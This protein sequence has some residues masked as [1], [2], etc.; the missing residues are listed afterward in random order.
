MLP[1]E[2]T[3]L[4]SDIAL[5][6]CETN[7]VELKKALNGTPHRLYDT[8]SSFAN[9]SGGGIIIFGI[10]EKD[11][12]AAC[13]VY[14]PQD[15]QI[16]VM[17]QANQMS[18]VLRPLFTVASINHKIIVSAEI[19]ECDVSEKPCYYKGTGKMR[20]SFI[21]VGDA[22]MPMTEYEI[23]SFEAFK[24]K[25]HDELRPIPAGIGGV[26]NKT[27]LGLYF[28]KIRSEKP[29]LAALT[30]SQ[31]MQLGGFEVDGNPTIASLLLFGMYPQGNFPQL[32]TTAVVVPGYEM[33]DI[34]EEDARFLDNR[35]IEGT[36][37]QMLDGSMS[38][39]L[40][41]MHVR[42]II[43]ESGKREDKAEY[44]IKAVREII[45]NALTHRDY[46]IHTENSP[47]RI[48][49]FSDR[50]EVENPG[51]L[52]G[53][54]TIDNLGKVGADTRNPYIASALEIMLDTENRFSGIPTIRYETKR[55]NLPDPV[56]ISSRGIFKVILYNG[57]QNTQNDIALEQ[58]SL[59]ERIIMLCRTPKSREEIAAEL[60]FS[61]ISY[62]ISKYVRP[63]LDTGRMTSTIPDRPKSKNQK[64]VAV[65][66]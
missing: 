61:S 11:N 35:K 12:Y 15:L 43:G 53:R 65:Q 44:P 51:G 46:S 17:E 58:R 64:Y 5:K 25:I 19:S 52:Y 63:L 4:V 60:G 41:N 7:N 26:L 34:G 39:I 27:D 50:L 14:D 42:T 33:G 20:G 57:S 2:L 24:R 6:K 59:D 21:R 47:V 13:G 66:L 40:H 23:Y 45:L 62:M 22:D 38:F 16:K 36:I 55:A 10:D 56:F 49:F 3:A 48:M 31:I 9:Q 54:L 28:A 32:C 18:P 37:P 8:L 30:D 29:N 1:E